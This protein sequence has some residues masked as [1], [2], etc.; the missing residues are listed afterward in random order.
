M[1]IRIYFLFKFKSA[2]L[3]SFSVHFLILTLFSGCTINAQSMEWLQ[4][5]VT[6][7]VLVQLH[8]TNKPLNLKFL[9][10]L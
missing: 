3:F 8:V 6:A 1:Y 7:A 10:L 9:N 5:H 2:I 4:F